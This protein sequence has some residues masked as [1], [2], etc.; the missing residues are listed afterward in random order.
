MISRDPKRPGKTLSTSKAAGDPVEV[1][2][3]RNAEDEAR[4]IVAEMIR[5]H[6]QG[7]TWEA[8]AVLYRGNALSRGFEEALMRG[9][10]PYVLI[11][12]VD[13][14]QRAE[15]KDALALLRILSTPDSVQADEAF[16]RVI[17]VPARGFGAKAL[18]AG[19]PLMALIT[20]LST[21]CVDGCC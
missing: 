3:F 9:R 6:A 12:D 16:R 21:D 4:G 10:V 19:K 7:V 11:G 8:M 14:Y 2:G 5:R 18:D 15:I 1:I 20:L 17:N 13:F